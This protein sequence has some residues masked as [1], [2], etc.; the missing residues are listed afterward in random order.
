ML[1]TARKKILFVIPS[2]RVGGAEKVL[3]YLLKYLDRKKFIPFLVLFDK[4]GEYLEQVPKDVVVYDLKK[5][6]RYHFFKMIYLLSYKIFPKLKPDLVISFMEYSNIVT[7]F[8]KKLSC[9]KPP[10]IISEHTYDNAHLDQR[11]RWLKSV[12][13]KRYY[14]KADKIIAVSKGVYDSLVKNYGVF[15]NKITV[16]YNGVDLKCIQNA[17]KEDLVTKVNN[18]V[19]MIVSCGRLSSVKNYPLLLDAFSRVQKEI[20]S[21]LLIIGDGEEKKSLEK[22]CQKLGIKDAVTFVGFQEN[23]FKYITKSDI[24]VLPSNYEG[25]GNVIIEAMACGVPVISTKC[26]SGPDEIITDGVNGVLVPVGDVNAMTEAILKLLKDKPL[27][28]RLVEAGGVG[29]DGFG[30]EKMIFGYERIFEIF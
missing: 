26:P 5:K 20:K 19:P 22:L 25:F 9:V 15:K 18:N 17:S 8:S 24:F 13:I 16:I 6:K 14:N 10:I 12:L 23:P 7:I 2:L 21:R 29:I 28:E 11:M 30:I 27:R 3:L 1:I 4:T